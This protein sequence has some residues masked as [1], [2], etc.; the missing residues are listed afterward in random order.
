MRVDLSTI[1]PK[2]LNV[3]NHRITLREPKQ[4]EPGRASRPGVDSVF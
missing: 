2:K 4:A 1:E 3:R